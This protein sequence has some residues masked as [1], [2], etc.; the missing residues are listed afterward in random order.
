LAEFASTWQ[1]DPIKLM[2]ELAERLGGA[3][4]PTFCQQEERSRSAP[5]SGGDAASLR[6]QWQI[7]RRNLTELE[8]QRAQHGITVPVH[9]IQG[10]KHEQV[11]I[12]RLEAQLRAAEG[13]R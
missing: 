9:I 11:E 2:R 12:A 6:E 13:S 1:P 5:A 3:H 8:K 10:I 4:F 7:H